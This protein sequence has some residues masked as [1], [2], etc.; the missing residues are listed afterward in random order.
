MK[1]KNIVKKTKKGISSYNT[2]V[3]END[4]NTINVSIV[5]HKDFKNETI[6]PNSEKIKI[7]ETKA[8]KTSVIRQGDLIIT[9]VGQFKA[10]V[11][12]QNIDGFLLGDNLIGITLSDKIKPNLLAA[13]LNSDKGQKLLHSYATGTIMKNL[14]EK[15]LF[16]IPIPI[17]PEEKQDNV[18]QYIQLSNK[19]VELLEKEIK[20]QS[21]I[22]NTMILKMLE[23][24]V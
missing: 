16:D 17:P 5:T 4:T 8:A 21:E 6:K 7:R 23:Q 10:A 13:Y 15:T 24:G 11:A 1:L 2:D 12:G 9:T 18:D 20:L 14:S 22:K 3:N 19:F